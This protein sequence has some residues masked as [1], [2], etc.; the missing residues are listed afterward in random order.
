VHHALSESNAQCPFLAYGTNWLAF[1]HLV[2]AV[3]F[4]GPYR[5]PVRNNW[6]ITFAL[7]A[8][9]RV[10]PLALIAGHVR[11]IPFPFRLIDCSFGVFGAVPLARCKLLISGLENRET[12]V[13]I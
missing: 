8:C 1:A 10:I 6:I 13:K 12:P 11:G 2:L 7:I 5:D 4:T 9:G 3:L